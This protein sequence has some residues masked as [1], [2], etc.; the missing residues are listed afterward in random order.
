MADSWLLFQGDGPAD[1]I[2]VNAFGQKRKP[3]IFGLVLTGP[4][5]MFTIF[6]ESRR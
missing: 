2:F 6:K 4:G 5:C 1:Q 3:T